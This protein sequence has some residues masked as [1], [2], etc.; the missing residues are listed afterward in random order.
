M[1]VASIL[2]FGRLLLYSV[3]EKCMHASPAHIDTLGHASEYWYA[4]SRLGSGRR[5]LSIQRGHRRSLNI[6]INR[7]RSPL[8]RLVP[9]SET[10]VL[11]N[12]ARLHAL[13]QG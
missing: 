6:N 4:G 2:K 10:Q 12:Q 1:A 11:P 5:W 8:M 13:C 3:W 7:I 9:R